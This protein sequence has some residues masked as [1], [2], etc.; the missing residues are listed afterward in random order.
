MTQNYNTNIETIQLSV[1][2]IVLLEKA[3]PYLASSPTGAWWRFIGEG[4]DYFLK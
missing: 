2:M 3:L 4:S 1:S